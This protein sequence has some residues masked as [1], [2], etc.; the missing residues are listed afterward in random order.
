LKAWF[1]GQVQVA[2]TS[3]ISTKLSSHQFCKNAVPPDSL[4]QISTTQ[5]TKLYSVLD[6]IPALTQQQRSQVGQP[7]KTALAVIVMDAADGETTSDAAWKIRAAEIAA[8][9]KNRI[10]TV[11]LAAD[12]QLINQASR[13]SNQYFL[14]CPLSS[15]KECITRGFTAARTL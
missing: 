8:L 2:S 12:S 14:V 6:A 9:G 10:V 1:S 7:D 13:I 4:R 15:A 5:G 3:T 11:L